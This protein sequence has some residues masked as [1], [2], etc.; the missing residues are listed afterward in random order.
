M[1]CKNQNSKLAIKFSTKVRQVYDG[2]QRNICTS[3]E[4]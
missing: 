2:K 1:S 3:L 4:G